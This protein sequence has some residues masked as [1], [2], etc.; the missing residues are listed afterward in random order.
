[1]RIV[2]LLPLTVVV[3]LL[4]SCSQS[5]ESTVNNRTSTVGQSEALS[6]Q[7]DASAEG[8]ASNQNIKNQSNASSDDAGNTDD[9]GNQNNAENTPKAAKIDNLEMT[10]VVMENAAVTI[11]ATVSGD[12]PVT[13]AWQ[14]DGTDI[15]AAADENITITDQ[16]IQLAKAALSDAGEYSLKVT[17]SLGEDTKKITLTVNPD[18]T[19]RGP[20]P[21][22][23]DGVCGAMEDIGWKNENGEMRFRL[24]GWICTQG[25]TAA[26]NLLIRLQRQA[27][28]QLLGENYKDLTK[29]KRYDLAQFCNQPVGTEILAGFN[30]FLNNDQMRNFYNNGTV[31][32]WIQADAEPQ[33]NSFPFGV[34]GLRTYQQG[35]VPAPN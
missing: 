33:K 19:Y 10:M 17:N 5:S 4:S 20:E 3:Y 30:V 18:T 7:S 25:S 14:K 27:N 26:S 22:C 32:M 1:M 16:K 2:F 21:E 8:T 11:E 9:T 23:S 28:G 12:A 15:D 34:I 13:Y 6:N 29:F 24:K 31:L 35:Q